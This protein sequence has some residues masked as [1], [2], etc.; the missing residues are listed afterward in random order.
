M[1]QNHYLVDCSYLC[2]YAGYSS[3]KQYCYNFDIPNSELNPE[4]DPTL[5][6]EFG[7]IFKGSLERCII[8]PL[9]NKIPIIDKSKFIFCIDC[10]RK[11][12]WRREIYPEY[13]LDRD[14]RDTG[15]DSFNLGRI[16]RY[17]YEIALPTICEQYNAQMVSCNCAEGDDVIAVLTNYFMNNTKDNIVI[18]SCDKDML[19]LYNDRVSIFNIEGEKREPKI[20]LEK[21]IK[22]QID[23]EISA[24][25]YLLFKILIGDAS[26]GIP[27]IKTGI[28][29]KKAWKYIQDKTMLKQLLSEDITVADSFM[30]NKKLISM[31][32]I[33]QKIHDIILEEYKNGLKEDRVIC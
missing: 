21:A 8:N 4:F 27:N 29:P 26:D 19:Q 24:N 18:I 31:K 6:S 11:N 23:K 32:E 3:F 30:R 15:K 2:Y 12:I 20:E 17:A 25:D 1:K 33:P 5:D 9:Y 7:E 28:G 14:I 10:A 13:K 16:F 22:Q